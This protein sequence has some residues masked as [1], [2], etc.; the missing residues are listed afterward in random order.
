M[1]V[2]LS[3]RQPYSNSYGETP[4]FS[5]GGYYT[6]NWTYGSPY[7]DP[8]L[9]HLYGPNFLGDFAKDIAVDRT[10]DG[11]GI[12]GWFKD[13]FNK[14]Q[15]KV[16]GRYD[17]RRARDDIFARVGAGGAGGGGT[18]GSGASGAASAGTSLVPYD[19]AVAANNAKATNGSLFSKLGLGW[20][21]KTGVSV[22]GKN[23]GK[24]VPWISG[25]LSAL[26]AVQGLDELSKSQESTDDLI[27]AIL[28]SASSNP[29]LGL[30]L[31]AD[32]KKLLRQIKNDDDYGDA[33]IDDINLAEILKGAGMGAVT[34]LPGGGIGALVGGIGGAINSGINSMNSAQIANQ[35]ELEGLLEALEMSEWNYKNAMKQRAYANMYY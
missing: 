4:N 11:G 30:D 7:D 24:A 27:G 16:K 20:N 1:A 8:S 29:N 2:T 14:A 15:A 13:N 25:G 23:V 22:M 31:T 5:R 10:M 12:V 19:P 32:Q 21:N 3:K 9:S 33:T 35:A 34:G 28:A 26:Q 6:P 18:V 17:A